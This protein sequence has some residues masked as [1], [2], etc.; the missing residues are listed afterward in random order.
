MQT[1][2]A[3]RKIDE[4]WFLSEFLE[5]MPDSLTQKAWGAVYDVFDSVKGALV[6]IFVLFTFCF[7][8]VGV[9]GSSMY[10]TLRNGDWLIATSSRKN[11]QYPDIVIV[12]QPEFMHEPLIK[13]VIAV[14]GD[15]LDINAETREVTVNG[16]VLDEPY[17]AEKIWINRVNTSQY[18]I[19]VP[20]GY[21]FVMGDNR[22][23]SADSRSPLVGFVDVRYVLGAAKMRLF[24]LGEFSLEVKSQPQDGGEAS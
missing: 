22:N 11:P 18:P 20:Q 19:T 16:V 12:T 10:P 7:R 8:I 5:S 15:V 23:G 3:I 1:T 21:L 24:P 13:R 17:I 2:A 9:E 4:F 6:I 14:A